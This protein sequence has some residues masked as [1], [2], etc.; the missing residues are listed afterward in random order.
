M[1]TVLERT[2]SQVR[3][4]IH[5]ARMS[6]LLSDRLSFDDID[7]VRSQLVVPILTAL[8][9]SVED[10]EETKLNFRLEGLA[11][12]S[13][14][15][16]F[17]SGRPCLLVEMRGMG[18]A[19]DQKHLFGE[20]LPGAGDAGFEWVLLTDGD[21]YDVFSAQT[22]L[23]IEHRSFDA[24]RI[25]DD[26]ITECLE[27]F[28]LFSR[29][30]IEENRIESVLSRRLVDRQ[31][32]R[33]LEE[34]IAPDTALAHLLLSKTK[35]LS[36][37]DVHSALARAKVTVQFESRSR[38]D[39][40]SET[41]AAR[42]GERNVGMS[43]AEVRVATWLQRRS[44]ERWAKGGATAAK[45]RTSQR[46]AVDRRRSSADRRKV[47]PERR[48]VRV[49]KTTERR[50]ERERRSD[51]RRTSTERRVTEDRRRARRMA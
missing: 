9:W 23:P 24:V 44:I 32:K 50:D 43:E 48:V 12:D 19:F 25:S 21:D 47:C 31:V 37:D 7:C 39:T 13:R 49:E 1:T 30:R 45:S 10:A 40:I 11:G 14:L 33:S 34:L 35:N 16:L 27:L 28:D 4:K 15:A 6:R 2:L 38:P 26:S 51:E 18:K 20:L 41:E 3:A 46:R 17:R 22:G 5:R 42:K 8:G 29:E 36:T